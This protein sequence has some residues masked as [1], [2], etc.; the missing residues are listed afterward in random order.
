[1]ADPVLRPR[2]QYV[3]AP[4]ANLDHELSTGSVANN[5]TY[6]CCKFAPH[7]NLPVSL[8]VSVMEPDT[9]DETM[10]IPTPPASQSGNASTKSK[11]SQKRV[12]HA[13]YSAY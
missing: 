8:I 4:F 5:N 6:G 3:E 12:K 13:E 11:R 7:G 1:M 2:L 10:T 9:H